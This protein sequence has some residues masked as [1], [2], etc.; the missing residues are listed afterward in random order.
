[1]AYRSGIQHALREAAIWIVVFSVG[2]GA[3]YYFEQIVGV[4]GHIRQLGEETYR[5]ST[6]KIEEQP[7][8]SFERAVHL[9]AGRSGHFFAKAYI[10]GRPVTV[11]VD[12]GATGVALTYEDARNIGLHP[13]DNDFTRRS[14]TANGIAR[15]APAML[16]SIRIGDITV[17]NVSASISEPGKLHVNLLGMSF[18]R[19]L[20]RFELRGK[21]LVLIQ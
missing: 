20:G 15:S 7:K 19:K 16:D 9:K 4:M 2:F 6:A 5:Q 10:N 3:F 11:M 8:S 12:T 17:R 13:R 1:M 14:R 21:E 18:I